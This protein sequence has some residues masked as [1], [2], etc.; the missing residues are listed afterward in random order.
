MVVIFWL[1]F[2]FFALIILMENF[3]ISGSEKRNISARQIQTICNEGMVQGI[4]KF[5]HA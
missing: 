2:G 1:I 3:A 5:G 4:I